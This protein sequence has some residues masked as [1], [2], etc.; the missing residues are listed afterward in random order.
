VT[1]KIFDGQN[2]SHVLSQGDLLWVAR[3]Y[4]D[5]PSHLVPD[6]PGEPQPDWYAHTLAA[7]R[8]RE[9][10]RLTPGAF[11]EVR[12][13]LR[14]ATFDAEARVELPEWLRYM[15]EFITDGGDGELAIR[16]RYECSVATLRGLNTLEGVED[17]IRAVIDY[18]STSGCV[19][20]LEDASI[21]LMYWGGDWLRHIG[22]VS[23]D[24]LRDRNLRLRKHIR[25]LLDATDASS[26][27]VRKARLHAVTANLCLHARLSEMQRPSPGTLPSSQET[28][29]LRREWEESGDAITLDV[30]H[31]PMDV[32]ETMDTGAALSNCYRGRG[33]SQLAASVKSSRCLPPPQKLEYPRGEKGDPDRS[34]GVR[35]RRQPTRATDGP[36]RWTGVDHPVND[37]AQHYP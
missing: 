26:H 12:D 8:G 18:A 31:G 34:S 10:R 17:D 5:L 23:A 4:L 7:L 37:D 15:R 2:V 21:H 3:R 25:G 9:T 19:S 30:G 14:R 11:S 32:A 1:L 20:M 36:S 24:E 6:V 13:G 27:P 35:T 16:A 29:V 22:T 28:S 33:R